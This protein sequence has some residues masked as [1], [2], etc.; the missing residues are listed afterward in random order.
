M[1]QLFGNLTMQ[2]ISVFLLLL[3]CGTAVV[4]IPLAHYVIAGWS[5]KRK[6]I[7]DGFNADARLAYFQMFCRSSPIP[8]LQ[9]ASAE[10]TKFH[11]KWYGRR[12]FIMPGLLLLLLSFTGVGVVTLTGLDRLNFLHNPLI[13]IP[14]TAMAGMAGAYLWVPSL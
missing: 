2:Q 11:A 12:Y 1:E 14:D 8:T 3:F 13:K 6:D 10:F 9:N 7:M 5:A 4:M